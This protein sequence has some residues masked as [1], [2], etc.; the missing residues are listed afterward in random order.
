L[1]FAK[2]CDNSPCRSA[3]ARDP[4]TAKTPQILPRL[5]ER[6]R[7]QAR[8]YKGFCAAVQHWGQRGTGV[9]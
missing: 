9:G 5:V 6:C 4:G 1:D 8:S 3:L 2:A 7:A